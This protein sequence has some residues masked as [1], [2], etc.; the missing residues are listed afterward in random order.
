MHAAPLS[1]GDHQLAPVQAGALA[2]DR[3]VEQAFGCLRLPYRFVQF[4]YLGSRE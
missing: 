4:L 1:G 2:P 3:L